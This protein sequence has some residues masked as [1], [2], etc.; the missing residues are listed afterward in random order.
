MPNEGFAR[1]AHFEHLFWL[2]I[3]GDHARFLSQMIPVEN[4]EDLQRAFQFRG[5]YDQLLGRVRKSPSDDILSNLT[6]EALQATLNFRTF[7]L[8]LLAKGLEGKLHIA[9]TFINHMVNELE[10]YLRIINYLQSGKVPPVGNPLHYHLLWLLDGVGHAAT[11]AGSLDMIEKKFINKS[12]E[13]QTIFENMYLK[14]VELA[15]YLRTGKE[16]FPAL[17]RFNQD[18][19]L[20][21]EIFKSFLE[22]ILKLELNGELLGAFMPL[23]ADHMVREECY[24]LLQLARS[25]NI[26]TEECDPTK[27][28]I[29]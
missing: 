17:S 15:G 2:Q 13:F 23:M 12:R 21:M 1:A 22:E 20:E 18:A 16:Q 29:E 8:Y 25:A 19:A 3:M 7:K 6:E 11:I 10:E 27:P 4:Q 26:K 24:Y 5:L 28:R 9:T 14:S